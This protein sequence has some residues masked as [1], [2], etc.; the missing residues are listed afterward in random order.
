MDKIE[1][2]VGDILFYRTPFS[3][4]KVRVERLTKTQVV[5][6]DGDRLRK[7]DGREVGGEVWTAGHYV[8]TTPETVKE[9]ETMCLVFRLR[10]L[11][12]AADN[13]AHKPYDDLTAQDVQRM[14]ET[15]AFL[16]KREV[17]L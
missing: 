3:L 9:Y 6:S 11:L 1:Y 5:L 16:Q 12:N 10:K 8:T 17:T 13:L 14:R 7:S 2:K 4:T 15:C